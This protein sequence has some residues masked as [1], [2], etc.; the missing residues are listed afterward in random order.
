MTVIDLILLFIRDLISAVHCITTGSG[1]IMTV[2]FVLNVS[3]WFRSMEGVLAFFKT[4][5]GPDQA[6]NLQGHISRRDTVFLRREEL[7]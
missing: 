7:T 5:D 6:Q 1:S 3:C 4:D 2:A